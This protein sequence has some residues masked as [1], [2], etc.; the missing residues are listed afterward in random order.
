MLVEPIVIT[1]IAVSTDHIYGIDKA[2]AVWFRKRL[3]TPAYHTST[4]TEKKKKEDEE[5]EEA[6][7]MW[8]RLSMMGRIANDEI[9]PAKDMP[10][11]VIGDRVDLKPE[12]VV[13]SHAANFSVDDETDAIELAG[14][15]DRHIRCFEE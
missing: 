15:Y 10:A 11:E 2:G 1:Q 6:K 5:D 7:K 14:H 9:P 3:P 13:T 4:A 12:E 8:K